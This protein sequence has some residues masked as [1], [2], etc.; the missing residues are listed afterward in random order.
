M[1]EANG[2]FLINSLNASN[3]QTLLE[4]KIISTKL[5]SHNLVSYNQP[6]LIGW[7]TV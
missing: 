4:T 5:R 3:W 2:F 6:T 1:I 7:C